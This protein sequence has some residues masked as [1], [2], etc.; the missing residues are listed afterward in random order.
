MNGT[1]F[2]LRGAAE[3]LSARLLIAFTATASPPVLERIEQVLFAGRS[4][5]WLVGNPDKPN[6]RI[7][8]VRFSQS[9]SGSF[10]SFGK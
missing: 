6:I 1:Y 7:S 8:V 10:S 2:E 4:V 3:A 9:L 5:S